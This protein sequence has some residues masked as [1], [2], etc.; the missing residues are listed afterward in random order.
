MIITY[1]DFRPIITRTSI[2]F[3]PS[4]VVVADKGY[5]SEDNYLFGKRRTLSRISV[6][7]ARYEHVPVWREHG[8]YGSRLSV[9]VIANCCTINETRMKHDFSHKRTIW[10]THYIKTSENTKQEIIIQV[11]PTIPT[12]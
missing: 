10:R 3:L 4:S 6:I 7:P 5:D 9:V 1:I 12:D 2:F 8:K 11:H